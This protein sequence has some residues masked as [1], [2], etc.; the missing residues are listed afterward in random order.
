MRDLLLLL[1]LCGLG[2]AYTASLSSD[3]NAIPDLDGLE[4]MTIVEDDEPPF[5]M[6]LKKPLYNKEPCCAPD[7]WEGYIGEKVEW[8]IKGRGEDSDEASDEDRRHDHHRHHHH[9]G[10][11]GRL[12]VGGKISVDGANKRVAMEI[13]VMQK[14]RPTNMTIIVDYGK[15]EMYIADMTRKTCKKSDLQGDMAKQCIP[16][17]ATYLG[18]VRFGAGDKNSMTTDMWAARMMM[19]GEHPMMVK[20]FVMVTADMCVPFWEQGF[21][22]GRGFATK[23]EVSFANVNTKIADPGVFTPPSFCA[24]AEDISDKLA[25]QDPYVSSLLNR[26]S[27]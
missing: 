3:D 1:C 16:A 23:F 19:K 27:K 12:G 14:P 24:K 8:L 9:H 7:T 22:I 2:L 18:D 21:G 17:N 6:L 4:E 15:H 5:S 11:G 25:M 13:G 20:M 10:R 26:F